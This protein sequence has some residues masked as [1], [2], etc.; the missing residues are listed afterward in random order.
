MGYT[1]NTAGT[2]EL[3]PLRRPPGTAAGLCTGGSLYV[4]MIGSRMSP[5]PLF[6]KVV[7]ENLACCLE[8]LFI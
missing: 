3:V 5:N 1:H 8:M 4:A 6:R 2:D 7:H